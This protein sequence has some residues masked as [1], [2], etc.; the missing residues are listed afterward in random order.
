MNTDFNPQ[1]MVTVESD[2]KSEVVIAKVIDYAI[3]SQI[4]DSIDEETLRVFD[5]DMIH[6]RTGKKV[7]IDKSAVY[8]WDTGWTIYRIRPIN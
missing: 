4:I 6:E 3:A 5:V 1:V 8:M 2:S 7:D